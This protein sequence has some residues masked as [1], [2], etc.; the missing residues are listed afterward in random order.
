MEK[1]RLDRRVQ[2]TRQILQEALI[3]LIMEKGYE[4]VTVQD[5]IDRANVGR[6]TFYAHFLDK[7]MLLISQFET[8]QADFEKHLEDKSPA[9]DTL[10]DFSLVMFRHAQHYQRVYQ[11]IVGKQSGQII[12]RHL[13]AYLMARIKKHLQQHW[14]GS[15]REAIPTDILAHYVVSTF[16]VLLI[17]WLDNELPHSPERMDK[18]YQQLIRNGIDNIT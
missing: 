7:E 18:M 13:E 17:W 16:M 12:Q 4:A 2:R 1:N 8:L 3:A 5:V 9:S 14:T 15:K 6:S 11:A 10:W